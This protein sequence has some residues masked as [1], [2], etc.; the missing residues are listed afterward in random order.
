[1]LL[2][3]A[4]A[5]FG[6]GWAKP[7]P[8][9]FANL[10]NGRTGEAMVAAAGPISNLLL[11]AA[12]GLVFRAVR[13]IATNPSPGQFDALQ[14]LLFFVEINVSLFIFNLI[15]VPPL[16]GTRVLLAALPP[17]Q[18]LSSARSCTSTV[19]TSCLP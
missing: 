9:N 7:T 3:S 18:A 10:R 14:I 4:Y 11:A 2:A 16:D 8:V 1:M 12:G 6:I 17:R 19:R 5:G 15:P 13:G